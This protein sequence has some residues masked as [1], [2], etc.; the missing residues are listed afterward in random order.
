MGE[1]LTAGLQSSLSTPFHGLDAKPVR[2]ARQNPRGEIKFP[3]PAPRFCRVH[4]PVSC[5]GRAWAV[6]GAGFIEIPPV[7]PTS[8]PRLPLSTVRTDTP[9]FFGGARPVQLLGSLAS[10]AL[11]V[12]QAGRELMLRSALAV[13]GVLWAG[14]V[15]RPDPTAQFTSGSG[16]VAPIRTTSREYFPAVRPGLATSSAML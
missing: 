14:A 7:L 8:G 13:G 9:R 1:A 5:C 2:D 15:L 11:V 4:G 12:S 3:P 16:A 6:G 10:L